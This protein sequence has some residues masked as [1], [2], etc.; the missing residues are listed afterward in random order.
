VITL[1]RVNGQPVMLNGDLIESI[2]ENGHTVIT[3]TTG[4]AVVVCERMAEI[5]ARIVAFKRKIY[6]PR[7]PSV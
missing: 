7:E 5:E 6:G 1:T 4:N 3:L 2:E